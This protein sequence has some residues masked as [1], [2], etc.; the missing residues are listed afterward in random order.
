LLAGP[1]HTA[2]RA[3]GSFGSAGRLELAVLWAMRK[4]SSVVGS[5]VVPGRGMGSSGLRGG[6]QL[7]GAGGSVMMRQTKRRL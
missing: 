6:R 5:I 7:A 4:Y 2:Q 1:L 3:D